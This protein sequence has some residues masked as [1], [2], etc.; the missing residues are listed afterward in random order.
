[1]CLHFLWPR[2]DVFPGAS[3]SVPVLKFGVAGIDRSTTAAQGPRRVTAAHAYA[4]AA[5]AAY[6]RTIGIVGCSHFKTHD[7]YCGQCSAIVRCPYNPP[8]GLRRSLM[9]GEGTSSFKRVG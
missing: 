6:L 5:T 1:M 9:E 2:L 3:F 8:T 7:C 4:A